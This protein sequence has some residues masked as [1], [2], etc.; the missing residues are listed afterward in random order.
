MEK[1]KYR[2][3]K[4]KNKTRKSPKT[5]RKAS[6]LFRQ[7]VN[8]NNDHKKMSGTTGGERDRG[9]PWP[10]ALRGG[11]LQPGRGENVALPPSAP[12]QAP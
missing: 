7:R 5:G 12:P 3:K 8:E 10:R 11:G 9:G 6:L 2:V 1:E 4:Q